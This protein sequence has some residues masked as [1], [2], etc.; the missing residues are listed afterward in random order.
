MT[1][2]AV[3]PPPVALTPPPLPLL[4][5]QE[6]ALKPTPSVDPKALALASESLQLAGVRPPAPSAPPTSIS[7]L[8]N[9]DGFG[10]LSDAAA[11]LLVDLRA[12]RQHEPLAVLRRGVQ[13]GEFPRHLE[14]YAQVR[15]WVRCTWSA[16]CV[17]LSLPCSYKEMHVD[18]FMGITCL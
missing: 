17:E 18:R 9:I 13:L 7:N 5:L 14:E 8:V 12:L 3:S 6:L 1:P 4:T 10:A 2:L 15:G 11:A 16:W